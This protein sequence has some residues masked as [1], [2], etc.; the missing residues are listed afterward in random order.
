MQGRNTA[1]LLRF[2]SDHKH[3][4]HTAQWYCKLYLLQVAI[5]NQ[6]A[7]HLYGTGLLGR[8]VF[9]E[10]DDYMSMRFQRKQSAHHQV[11]VGVRGLTVCRA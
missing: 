9:L 3:A 1:P 4:Y 2:S 5:T 10:A 6:N 7:R 11:D 8:L